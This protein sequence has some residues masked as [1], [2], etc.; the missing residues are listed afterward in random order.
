[1]R[2]LAMLLIGVTPP[3]QPEVSLTQR[4]GA[5]DCTLLIERKNVSLSELLTLTLVIRG[6]APVEVEL[7]RPLTSSHDWRA[8]AGEPITGTNP[9]GT[10]TWRQSFSFEPFQV[11]DVALP[12]QPIRF[13]TGNEVRDQTLTWAPQV[14]TVTSS[15]AEVDLGSAKPIVGVEK[16]PPVAEPA[17]WHWYAGAAVAIGA[18]A[19]IVARGLRRRD[20]Q[21]PRLTARERALARIDA[22]EARPEQL[23]MLADALRE[24]LEEHFQ[25]PAT[26]QTTAEFDAALRESGVLNA[27]RGD[28]VRELLTR[29]DLV[30]FAGI[31]PAREACEGLRRMAKELVS[32]AGEVRQAG[33]TGSSDAVR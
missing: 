20:S 3:P 13:R 2:L 6:H 17:P 9:D 33:P 15:I 8:R 28:A 29:C 25:L 27:P 19:L 32:G 12:L 7:P 24:F 16:L 31:Y 18:L 10:Q 14:I 23:P 4:I 22:L 26:R 21:G 30:K 5:A 11:G 1:M